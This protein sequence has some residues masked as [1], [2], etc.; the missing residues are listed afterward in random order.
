MIGLVFAAVLL[1]APAAIAQTASP[2]I[3]RTFGPGD[4]GRKGPA[5]DYRSVFETPPAEQEEIS[6]KK[7][8]DDIGRLGGHAGHLKDAGDAAPAPSAPAAVVPPPARHHH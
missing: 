7:A 6:W 8:N 1:A 4:A 2:D 3:E 5:L